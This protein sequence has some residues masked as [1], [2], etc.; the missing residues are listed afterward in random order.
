LVEGFL[1]EIG[2]RGHDSAHV[3]VGA[4]NATAIALYQ[5]AGFSTVTRFEMHAGTD[6]LL[7][8]WPRPSEG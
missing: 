8:Q 7:M 4:G 6:S 1:E 2:R 5:S 3:V